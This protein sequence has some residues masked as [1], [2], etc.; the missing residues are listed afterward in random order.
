MQVHPIQL[1]DAIDV[2]KGPPHSHLEV[3]TSQLMNR[4]SR[5][6]EGKK[7]RLSKASMAQLLER[8]IRAALQG[9]TREGLDDIDWV[10][11]SS[12]VPPMSVFTT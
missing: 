4:L 1:D 7:G 5:T 11:S 9:V 3:Q 2:V 12:L 8:G 6:T 10:R